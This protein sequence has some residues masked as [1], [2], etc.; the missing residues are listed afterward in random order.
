MTTERGG[1]GFAT[2]VNSELYLWSR[3]PGSDE[4][5]GWVESRVIELETLFPDDVLSA[6]LYV[7]GFAEGVDVVFV[8]TDREL[9]TIDLKSIRVTKVPK[10]IWL[11]D[12]FPY[13]SFYTPGTSL[14]PP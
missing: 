6:S 14:I 1:L 13:M 9:F 8:R 12:I 3:E 4:D 11:S 7:T 5:A 10:D 2:V